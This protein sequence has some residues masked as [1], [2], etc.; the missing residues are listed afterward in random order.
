MM[1]RLL[2]LEAGA[3]VLEYQVVKI[4]FLSD[5][6]LSSITSKSLSLKVPFTAT[7]DNAWIKNS[8][9][10]FDMEGKTVT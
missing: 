1:S 8:I 7:L 2:K 10:G 9:A 4:N 3:I 5:T 6:E